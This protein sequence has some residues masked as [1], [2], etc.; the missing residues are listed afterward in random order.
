M[1]SIARHAARLATAASLLFG[2]SLAS[3]ATGSAD[4]EGVLDLRWGDALDGAAKTEILQAEIVGSNGYTYPVSTQAAL[5]DGLPLYELAGKQVVASIDSRQKSGAGF[6]LRGVTA[7]SDTA[8]EPV[9]DARPWINLLCKFADNNDEPTSVAQMDAVFAPGGGLTGFWND[10]SGGFIDL[11][12]TRTLGWYVLPSPRAAY[13][14]GNNNPNLGKLLADC[15]SAAGAALADLVQAEDH[16]GINVLVNGSLGCCAWGGSSHSKIGGVTKTWRVTWVPPSAYLNIAL[17]GHEL[18]HAFGMPH[19][20]NSD[21]D[22]STY[23]NPWDLLS[24]STGHAVLQDKFGRIPKTPAA[25]HL[26]RAGWLGADEKRVLTGE[27]RTTV[28]LQRIDQSKPGQARLLRIESPEWTDGRYYTVEARVRSGKYDAA[29]PDEGVLLYEVKPN[30]AQPAWL[31]DANT[32]AAGYSNTR[33]VVFKP[34][35]RY[36]AP[37]RSFELRVHDAD[38]NGFQVEVVLPGPGFDSGFE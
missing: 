22:N 3:A 10:V 28:Q 11:S 16:A 25:Y 21:S 35:D 18:G 27:S 2:L 30:R 13:V 36:I 24:D 12:K 26:D 14:D 5:A 1:R 37:D 8:P 15:A 20:N 23:D 33:S 9:N 29:L 31:V 19:S 7:K 38:A 6:R 4:V 17:L 34:G 32:P